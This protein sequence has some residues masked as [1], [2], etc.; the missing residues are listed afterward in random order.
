MT[1]LHDSMIKENAIFI[2]DSHFKVADNAFL[3]FLANI[4]D[5]CQIFFMGDIFHFLLGE[6]DSSICE[7]ADLINMISHLS[8][9]H[10]IFFLEGNHDFYL[11]KL[12]SHRIKKYS[13]KICNEKNIKI[14]PYYTQPIVMNSYDNHTCILAHG[15]LWISNFYNLY[16][17]LLYNPFVMSFFRILDKV[18]FGRVYERVSARINS[19]NIYGFSFF[20]QDFEDFMKDRIDTYKHFILNPIASSNADLRHRFCIIEG[21]FHLGMNM[22]VDNIVYNSLNS[23]YLDKL[24]LTLRHGRIEVL[25]GKE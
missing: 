23:C 9:N 7:N 4:P 11:K 6:V 2:A 1:L 20:R 8:C 15:D 5:N 12:W 17:R 22:S 13:E 25:N 14:F 3:D 18:S 21:H 24:Y 10:E 19:R 16:R